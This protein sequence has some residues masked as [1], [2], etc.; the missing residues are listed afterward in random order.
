MKLYQ[1]KNE[2]LMAL[3]ELSSDE[4]LTPQI[5]EDS[6]AGI[7]AELKEKALSIGAYIKNCESDIE[8]ITKYIKDMQLKRTRLTSKIES[9]EHYL[10]TTMQA[11]NQKKFEGVEFNIALRENAEHVVIDDTS[12]I[13]EKYYEEIIDR[14]LNKIALKTAIQNGEKI[15]GAH[16][17]RTISLTIK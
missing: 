16:L 14:K 17:E 12:K 6:L 13:E 9:L 11:C 2:Y 8:A 4:S 7:E 1:I 10:I 3:Y 5:I 15:E